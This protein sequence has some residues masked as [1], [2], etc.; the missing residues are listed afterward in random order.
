M[1]QKGHCKKSHHITIKAS[2]YAFNGRTLYSSHNARFT[3]VVRFTAEGMEIVSCS[4]LQ[5]Y[6]TL[7]EV[8]M[9]VKL[10]IQFMN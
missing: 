6:L 1:F 10:K 9:I 5:T 3:E 7:F 8:E 2:F 4:D